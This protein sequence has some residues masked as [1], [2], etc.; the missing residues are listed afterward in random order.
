MNKNTVY[1]KLYKIK[2]NNQCCVKKLF[3]HELSN[4]LALSSNKNYVPKAFK[5]IHN[6]LIAP[7]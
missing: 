5:T 3:Y 2:N 4:L 1:K 7:K 6:K